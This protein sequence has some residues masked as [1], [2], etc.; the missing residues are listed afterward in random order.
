MKISDDSY[1]EINIDKENIRDEYL[2][3]KAG[4]TI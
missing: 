3:T 2:V 1:I 4:D